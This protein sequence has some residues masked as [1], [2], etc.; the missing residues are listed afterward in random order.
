MS[1]VTRLAAPELT[2]NSNPH[3]RVVDSIVSKWL[4]RQRKRVADRKHGF[5]S[6][7]ADLWRIDFW[8]I[9][10]TPAVATSP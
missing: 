6:W 4:S 7:V 2:R 1:P 8:T 10:S 5:A 9:A 3:S